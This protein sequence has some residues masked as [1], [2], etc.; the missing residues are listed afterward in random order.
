MQCTIMCKI[1]SSVWFDLCAYLL[2]CVHGLPGRCCSHSWWGSD[3]VPSVWVILPHALCQPLVLGLW[4]SVTRRRG[5]AQAGFF[6]NKW[7]DSLQWL[8]LRWRW[9]WKLINVAFSQFPLMGGDLS[10][11]LTSVRWN[12]LHVLGN[13][14]NLKMNLSPFWFTAQTKNWALSGSGTT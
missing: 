7:S 6:Q 3:G 11:A 2:G 12:C 9:E 1:I 10:S 8:S 5:P 13:C 14:V 4:Y